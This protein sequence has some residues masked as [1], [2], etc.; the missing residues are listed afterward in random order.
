MYIAL[1]DLRFDQC[2]QQKCTKKCKNNFETYDY[3]RKDL[4]MCK[5]GLDF[6]KST[7]QEYI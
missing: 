2:S 3:K 1:I 5:K 4:A 6:T 7:F